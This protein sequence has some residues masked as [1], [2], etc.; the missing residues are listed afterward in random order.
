MQVAAKTN[1]VIS[2]GTRFTSSWFTAITWHERL[3]P[4]GK[5]WSFFLEDNLAGDLPGVQRAVE[6]L[7]ACKRPHRLKTTRKPLQSNYQYRI[8]W[9]SSSPPQKKNNETKIAK[10]VLGIQ[11]N[12]GASMA[13]SKH[14]SLADGTNILVGVFTFKKFVWG[15]QFVLKCKRIYIYVFVLILE[16]K[17]VCLISFDEAN[18]IF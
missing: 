17:G 7:G 4:P 13:R 6:C 5:S 2:G 11:K 8:G 16:Y 3:N 18:S 14:C 1:F 10:L 12:F 9:K 15:K